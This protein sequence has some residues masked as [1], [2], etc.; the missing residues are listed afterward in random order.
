M[1]GFLMPVASLAART[2]Q[3]LSSVCWVSKLWWRQITCT[4]CLMAMPISLKTARLHSR[5]VTLRRLPQNQAAKLHSSFGAVS[6]VPLVQKRLQ[7][8]LVH[9]AWAARVAVTEKT[10]THIAETNCDRH[11]VRLSLASLSICSFES[12]LQVIFCYVS[13]FT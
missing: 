8:C 2:Q 1:S 4:T 6:A 11:R 12:H 3:T 7:C 10:S 5:P 9:G 13:M